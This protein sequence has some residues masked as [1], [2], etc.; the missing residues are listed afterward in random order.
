MPL[1]N[2]EDIVT[3]FASPTLVLAGPGAGKTYLLA[4]RVKRLLDGG[5]DKTS[6]TVLTFGRDA[7]R[8]MIEE[9][10]NPKGDFRIEFHNLP[11][12]FTMHALGL[13]IV[14]EKPRQVKLLKTDLE[15]QND[16]E[17]KRLLFRDA[18]LILGFTEGDS[19]EAL[20]CKQC[21]DCEEN[22]DEENC[23]ICNKYREIMSK[24]NHVDFDDQILFACQ[25]LENNSSIL[26]KYQSQ[27]EHLLVDE[28]QDINAAQFR[29]IE[30]LSRRNRNGLFV[31]GDDAQSIYGFRGGDPK[32]ILRFK[33][34]F[35]GAEVTTL[36]HSWRCHEN[37][38]EDS[39]KVL[40]KYY[41]DWTGKPDL[42]YHMENGDT[43]Y[44]WHL[45][46][47][48][49]EAKRA[50]NIAQKAIQEKKT[51]MILVPKKEFFILITKK[52]TK[53][54][55]PH[56]CSINLLP[57]RVSVAKRFIK[58]VQNSDDN[59]ITRLVVEDLINKGIAHVPGADKD[60]RSTE[61]TIENRIIEETNVAKLWESV[62]KKNNLFS[63]IKDYENSNK[64]LEK[65]KEGLLSI[66]DSYNDFLRDNRGEFAKKLALV[67]GIWINPPDMAE[68]ILKVVQLIEAE[69]PFGSGLVPLMTMR[70]A[71]GLEADVVIIVGLEDDIFPN[72]RSKN[73]EEEARLLYV[74]MT[75]A[76][77]KLYLFHSFK[78][79]RDISYKQDLTG[80]PKTRFLKAIGRDSVWKGARR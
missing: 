78:R 5:T 8:H 39:F 73:V 43:P 4:D 11:F 14:Q 33:D 55:V 79:S 56:T 66:E 58:W 1:N 76:K 77:E 51:V 2:Y 9:L 28:Y 41:T 53:R 69:Q 37:I 72:P 29:L 71:K 18:A 36:A 40:K 42:E 60:R 57:E 45:P 52:L 54:Q 35:P 74:S 32:F 20:E 27:A 34:N 70:K 68:D 50:A 75:R 62:D 17:V 7:S 3:H 61:D 16:E 31:V 10:V 23:Q 22:P 26:M 30:L 59:F 21:G 67:T 13:K 64:I 65:I 44:I 19:L 49:E 46:S 63:V 15:V 12:V 80:K 25:I 38:M 48:N 24:C 47:E 6:I